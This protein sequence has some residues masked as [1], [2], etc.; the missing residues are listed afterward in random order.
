MS[1]AIDA[2]AGVSAGRRRQLAEMILAACHRDGLGPGSRLPTERQLA[3][4]LATTR[5]SVRHALAVLEADG[6]VSRE[7]GRGTYLRGDPGGRPPG[8]GA[9]VPGR[10]VDGR[11]A[12]RAAG[13]AAGTSQAGGPDGG[14]GYAPAD[15]MT[16]RRMVEPAA[17]QLVV[18]WATAADFAEIERCLA[19]GERADGYDEFEAWDLALHRSVMTA[20][21]S[22]LLVRLYGL[23]ED[24]RHGQSWGDLKRRS[25]SR[26]RQQ[27][28]QSDHQE[29][30][31][32][33]RARDAERAAE[34]M[35]AHL[36]RV[37]SYLFGD[38]H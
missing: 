26:E 35:R 36:A 33:L 13:A 20:S 4:E 8:P 6:W 30:V 19:G 3:L 24:A 11:K 2:G 21:H 10:I 37:T 27:A 14:A 5:T 32:A 15:V 22:P 25:A 34:A 7:V 38:G 1:G 31:T 23:I 18:A 17:M 9:A 29:L 16:I 12:A 28:Y